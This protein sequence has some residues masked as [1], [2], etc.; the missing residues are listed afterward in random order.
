MKRAEALGT[1]GP[2]VL[3]VIILKDAC[4]LPNSTQPS[5]EVH[6]L[7]N[8]VSMIASPVTNLH[9]GNGQAFVQIGRVLERQPRPPDAVSIMTN[10]MDLNNVKTRVLMVAQATD[11]PLDR[12]AD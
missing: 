10:C 5:M 12:S 2:V 8:R 11:N 1:V 9:K 7:L 4:Q 6:N 3:L